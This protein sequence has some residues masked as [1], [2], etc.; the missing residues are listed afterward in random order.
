M[1]VAGLEEAYI[2]RNLVSAIHYHDIARNQISRRDPS[3]LAVPNDLALG[4]HHIT[5]RI[6]C[7]FGLAFLH[8]AKYGVQYDDA[9]DYDGVG[10]HVVPKCG[11]RASYNC[12]NQQDDHHRIV[13]LP[14]ETH[15]CGSFLELDFIGTMGS[16]ALSS[17]PAIQALMAGFQALK[18]FIR[19]HLIPR[20]IHFRLHGDVLLC[21]FSKSELLDKITHV[22]VN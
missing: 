8:E 2:S 7:A 6:Q 15:P 10:K 12:G 16:Q 18:D 19:P 14:Q 3:L 4:N 22:Q 21:L 1:D 17:D 13:E 9:E 11:K 20:A 5:Q